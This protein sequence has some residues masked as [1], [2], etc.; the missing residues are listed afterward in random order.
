VCFLGGSNRILN[1]Y[2]DE[3]RTLM[4]SVQSLKESVELCAK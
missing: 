3:L 1:Y 4:C 2:L